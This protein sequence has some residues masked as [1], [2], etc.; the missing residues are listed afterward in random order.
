MDNLVAQIVAAGAG[1]AIFTYFAVNLWVKPRYDDDNG[2][3]PKENKFTVNVWTGVV[4]LIFSLMLT[5]IIQWGISLD[6]NVV[7]LALQ[8]LLAGIIAAAVATFGYEAVKNYGERSSINVGNITE[9]SGVAIGEKS[10]S[11]VRK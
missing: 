1:S 4:A 11:K 5:T 7:P 9:S 8:S 2:D 6:I 3:V 10:D